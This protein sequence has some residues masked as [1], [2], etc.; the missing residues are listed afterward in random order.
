[1]EGFCGREPQCVWEEKDLPVLN[2]AANTLTAVVSAKGWAI[3]PAPFPSLFTA[4]WSTPCKWRGV[5]IAR[6]LEGPVSVSVVK[7]KS[8]LPFP[9]FAWRIFSQQLPDVPGSGEWCVK[10]PLA[11]QVA[12]KHLFQ[13]KEAPV[14]ASV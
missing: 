13:T 6:D 14:S 1:M 5:E 4:L 11:V 3:P 12:Y 9:T 2:I 7:A 10:L 8:H